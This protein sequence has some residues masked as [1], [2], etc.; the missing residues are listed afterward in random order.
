MNKIEEARLTARAIA[1]LASY[2]GDNYHAYDADQHRTNLRH[3]C[4]YAQEIDK[5][6]S[7]AARGKGVATI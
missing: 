6:L 1:T 7:T 4:D 3:I 2:Y 5:M